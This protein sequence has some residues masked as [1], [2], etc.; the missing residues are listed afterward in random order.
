MGLFSNFKESKEYQHKIK[1]QMKDCRAGRHTPGMASWET[2]GYLYSTCIYC[3]A[4]IFKNS[5]GVWKA[6]EED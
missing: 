5:Q 6:V 4:E 3:N 1:Q 2:K